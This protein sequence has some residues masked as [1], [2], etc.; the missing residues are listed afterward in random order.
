MGMI[1]IIQTLTIKWSTAWT[2]KM[3]SESTRMNEMISEKLLK[4]WSREKRVYNTF[5]TEDEKRISEVMGTADNQEKLQEGGFGI[6]SIGMIYQKQ[7][8]EIIFMPQLLIR[9][10]KTAFSK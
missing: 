8:G 2:E 3:V 9:L 1:E 5:K 7:N 4:F 6:I 10:P